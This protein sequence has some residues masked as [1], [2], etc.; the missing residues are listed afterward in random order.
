V[1]EHGNITIKKL[2]EMAGVSRGTVDR[3]LNDRPGV[4]PTVRERILKLEVELNYRPNQAAKALGFNKNPF[5]IGIL[6]P[7]KEVEFFE[8]VRAGVQAAATEYQDFGLRIEEHFVSDT[9]VSEAVAVLEDLI[10]RGVKGLMVTGIDH[11]QMAQALQ[12]AVGKGIPLVTYNSD[13][14]NCARACFVG[15]DLV[16]SGRIAAELM[17][18][19]LPPTAKILVVTSSLQFQAQKQRLEGFQAAWHGASKTIVVLEGLDLHT[20]TEQTIRQALVEHPDVEGIYLSVSPMRAVLSAL[21]N[22][23]EPRIR[24]VCN[25]L[26]PTTRQALLD[27]VVDFTILQ[28][29]FQQGYRPLRY[30]FEKITADHPWPRELDFVESTIVIKETLRRNP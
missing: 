7:P 5:V 21:K 1:L 19:M 15:Q 13:I 12:R 2:A 10:E 3:V 8:G 4:S 22:R 26:L 28:D 30:L 29:E 11:P 23:P 27:G 18:K 20:M 9:E 25:D 24:V 17:A 14:A 6:L 16:Q